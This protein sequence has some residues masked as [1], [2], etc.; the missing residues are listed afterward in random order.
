MLQFWYESVYVGAALAAMI[1]MTVTQLSQGARTRRDVTL[2]WG[3]FI[4]L[5]ALGTMLK[6]RVYWNYLLFPLTTASLVATH[7]WKTARGS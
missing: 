5:I 6:S 2:V 4:A 1:G 3:V 7:V